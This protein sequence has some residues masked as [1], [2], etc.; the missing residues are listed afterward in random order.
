MPRKW[1]YEGVAFHALPAGFEPNSAPVYRFWSKPLNT[2]FYTISERERD[3]LVDQFA[4]VWAY[5]GEVFWAY[6][7]GKQPA[8]TIPVHRF[9][10]DVLQRHFYTTDEAPEGQDD[11]RRIR[12]SGSRVHCLV[13]V[14]IAGIERPLPARR[15]GARKRSKKA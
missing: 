10:S 8:D 13:R 7:A 5:E 9:W 14:R 4:Y 2:H 12:T 1:T 3:K 11:P 6:A 15:H